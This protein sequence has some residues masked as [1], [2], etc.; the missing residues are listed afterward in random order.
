MRSVEFRLVA[1]SSVADEVARFT[2]RSAVTGGTRK[3]SPRWWR[4]DLRAV[5]TRVSRW[6]PG[7]T[8]AAGG[9]P[10]RVVSVVWN[11]DTARQE[12]G[13]YF[14]LWAVG[15]PFCESSLA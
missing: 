5:P 11:G 4:K 7:A 8:G 12:S 15:E 10:R 3:G 1:T 2:A 6:G 14:R 9:H 13:A